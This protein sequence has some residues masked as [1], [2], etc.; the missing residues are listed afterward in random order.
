MPKGILKM[1]R[2]TRRT[3]WAAL[4]LSA[5]TFPILGS[6]CPGNGPGPGPGLGKVAII[7]NI[8]LAKDG[9]VSAGNGIIAFGNDS[10]GVS[11]INV[12]STTI[13]DIPGSFRPDAV[14]CAGRKVVLVSDAATNS[15]S[16]YD[17]TNDSL[18]NV[19]DT[20]VFDINPGSFL[21]HQFIDVDGSL[22]TILHRGLVNT[23]LKLIDV[24]GAV[25]VVTTYTTILMAPHNVDLDAIN[26]QI[27]V[28]ED[29]EFVTIFDIS[30]PASQTPTTFDILNDAGI[31]V[32]FFPNT[33]IGSNK[34]LFPSTDESVHLLSLN[35]GSLDEL[36]GPSADGGTTHF[37]TRGGLY[38]YF[39]NRSG[40]GD[41][42]GL[43]GYRMIVGDMVDPTV[44]ELGTGVDLG[45]GILEGFGHS[46]AIDPSGETV[47][48]AGRFGQSSGGGVNEPTALQCF[49]IDDGWDVFTDSNGDAVFAADPSASTSVVAFKVED[50]AGAVLGY[51]IP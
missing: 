32:S 35:D 28:M 11:Y 44:F 16:V 1:T 26:G 5:L 49:N 47:Y 4:T 43:S 40:Q 45:S 42:D 39:L 38:V 33:L 41:F 6:S 7:T 21:E 48:L 51:Y 37:E 20:D 3:T 34:V 36:T 8:G 12:G 27:V 15:L 13:N 2:S 14:F 46:S 50:G 29:N 17:T 23:E 25:P 30:L 31:P 22:V 10:G 18:V 24:S 9:L 19:P